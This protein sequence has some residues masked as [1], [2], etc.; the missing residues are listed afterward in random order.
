MWGA[1]NQSRGSCRPKRQIG[2]NETELKQELTNLKLK[3][4]KK[5]QSHQKQKKESDKNGQRFMA[6]QLQPIL[7]K[8]VQEKKNFH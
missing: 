1:P 4:A 8:R 7:R 2:E 5:S 3:S 6:G